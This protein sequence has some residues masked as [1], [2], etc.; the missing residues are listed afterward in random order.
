MKLCL[1]RKATAPLIVVPCGELI[2]GKVAQGRPSRRTQIIVRFGIC[3][4]TVLISVSMPSFV[5]VL[6]FVGCFSVAL[7]A[8]CIPPFLHLILLGNRG[9]PFSLIWVID[10]FMFVWGISATAIS[11]VYTYKSL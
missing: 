4:I 6:S 2:E 3:L 11:T 1:V 8:F 7:V 5:T 10:F 9:T